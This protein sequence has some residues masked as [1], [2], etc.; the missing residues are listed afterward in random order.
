MPQHYGVPAPP[1]FPLARCRAWGRG[2][3]EPTC[4][5]WAEQP[6]LFFLR[7]PP[8]ELLANPMQRASSGGVCSQSD[9][10]RHTGEPCLGFPNPQYAAAGRP[11]RGGKWWAKVLWGW[12]RRRRVVCGEG[13]VGLGLEENREWGT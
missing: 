6:H 13:A 8:T 10:P 2:E 1:L 7:A 11:G 5:E 12:Q 3:I 4:S 9:P